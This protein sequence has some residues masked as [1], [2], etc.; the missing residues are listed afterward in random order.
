MR[1]FLIF[2]SLFLSFSLAAAESKFILLLGPSG[3]G[4]S[5]I[6]GH[7]RYADP[8]FVYISPYTTR[9]LRPGETD[10][11]HVELETIQRLQ[12]EEKLLTVNEI[13]GIFYATPKETID[14][15]LAE[16]KFPILDWPVE[17]MDV[18]LSH[19][20]D[21]LFVIYIEPENL[22]VLQERLAHDGRDRDGKRFAA[23]KEE[24]QNYYEGKYDHLIDIKIINQDGGDKEVATMIYQLLYQE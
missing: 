3:V 16:G 14:L 17:K 2:F 23:G 22:Q 18:M 20:E 21:Q 4:K 6:I 7:L 8:R 5:T 9:E 1:I 12:E 10:K 24:L 11:I 15:S 13:Y 19:Y